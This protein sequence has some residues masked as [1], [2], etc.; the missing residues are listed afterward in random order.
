[1]EIDEISLVDRPANQHGLVTIAK[2][3]E[4]NHMTI[5]DADGDEVFEDE[6]EHGDVVYAED[7]TELVFVE[8]DEEE[9]EEYEPELAGAFGKAYVPTATVRNAKAAARG[10]KAR[11]KREG[12]QVARDGKSTPVSSRPK[13]DNSKP[14]GWGPGAS[15]RDAARAWVNEGGVG[16]LPG[17]A[18]QQAFRQTMRGRAAIGARP[19][20]YAG[21]ALVTGAAGGEVHGRMKKGLGETVYEELSKALTIGDRDEVVSKMAD[22]IEFYKSQTEQT[23]DRLEKIEYANEVAHYT[24]VAKSYNLPIAPERLGLILKNAVDTMPQADLD[25]LDRLLSSTGEQLY[26]EVGANGAYAT[27]EIME[28]VNALAYEAIGKA[29]VTQEQAIVALFDTNPAAYDEYLAEQKG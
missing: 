15:R 24:E 25:E 22:E 16:K 28:Q 29:D 12:L 23:L 19:Y 9:A 11:A 1:M 2:R 8:D 7:G 21:G 27:S 5:Y 26:G 6:L 20:T 18:R 3:A 17:Q 4:E 13:V 10:A 14:I